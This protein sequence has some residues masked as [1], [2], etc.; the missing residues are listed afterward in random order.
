VRKVLYD[1]VNTM[2][3]HRRA[4]TAPPPVRYRQGETDCP[5]VF[6]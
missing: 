6:T 5:I 1:G 2:G 3:S 4:D